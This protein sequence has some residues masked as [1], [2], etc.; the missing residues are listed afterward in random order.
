M[1][2]HKCFNTDLSLERG[3]AFSD[4]EISKWIPL[5]C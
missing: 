2:T 3:S 5:V 1:Y 4:E